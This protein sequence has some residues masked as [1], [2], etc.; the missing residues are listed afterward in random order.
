MDPSNWVDRGDPNGCLPGV[1]PE[2]PT[3]SPDSP[4]SPLE[5]K[6]FFA[7]VKETLLVAAIV[8][9]VDMGLTGRYFC[10]LFFCPIWF[11][12]ALVKELVVR[13]GW[14]IAL[15]RISVP[16]L[17]LAS[18]SVSIKIQRNIGNANADRI[19]KA[20]EE[21]PAA[22]GQYPHTL[23]DL[24]PLYLRCV[25]QPKYCLGS[26]FFDFDQNGCEHMLMW[27]AD[28]PY[29]RKCYTFEDKRWGYVD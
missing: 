22:N 16:V 15:F 17:V 8:L 27:Y 3:I 21:Y 6:G 24:V 11:L 18:A 28:F 13:P 19:I 10:S 9:F 26:R 7:S 5:R 4:E 29:G 12:Y 20:C 2:P 25:P 1:V 14:G 23:E